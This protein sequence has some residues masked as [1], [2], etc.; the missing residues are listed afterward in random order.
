MCVFFFFF[1]QLNWSLWNTSCVLVLHVEACVVTI[2]TGSFKLTPSQAGALNKGGRK[3]CGVK[4]FGDVS[5]QG[6]QMNILGLLLPLAPQS[7]GL[8][9]H[10]L[11]GILIIYALQTEQWRVDYT[12]LH[13]TIPNISPF[14]K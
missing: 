12:N 10:L 3:S 8:D 1:W 7:G 5:L 9:E 4:A 14:A 13:Q 2:N 11:P 6:F